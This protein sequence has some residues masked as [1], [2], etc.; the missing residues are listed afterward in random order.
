M[1]KNVRL[2]D[3]ERKKRKNVLNIVCFSKKI[4]RIINMVQAFTELHRHNILLFCRYGAELP[5]ILTARAGGCSLA[6]FGNE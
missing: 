2:H 6:T 1:N 3:L 5:K 4:D